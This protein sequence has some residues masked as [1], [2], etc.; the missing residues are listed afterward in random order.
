[1]AKILIEVTD[2]LR[3]SVRKDCYKKEKTLKQYV[4][5]AIEKELKAVKND[6]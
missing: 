4:T 1:M 5:M 2:E 6:D 3:Q